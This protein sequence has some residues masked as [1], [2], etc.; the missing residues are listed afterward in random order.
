MY[1]NE[2]G[3]ISSTHVGDEKYTRNS[4]QKPWKMTS[5][6]NAFQPT[7]LLTTFIQEKYSTGVEEKNMMGK[8]KLEIGIGEQVRSHRFFSVVSFDTISKIRSYK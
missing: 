4:V 8:L 3:E 1:E 2:I 7:C 5:R 6:C